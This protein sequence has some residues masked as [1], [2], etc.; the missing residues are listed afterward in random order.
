MEN[1]NLPDFFQAG[2]YHFFL[3][4]FPL[5]PV[6]I[7]KFIEFVDAQIAFHFAKRIDSDFKTFQFFVYIGFC[8]YG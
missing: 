5:S 7:E 3:P 8:L 2:N 1:G 4:F 6:L